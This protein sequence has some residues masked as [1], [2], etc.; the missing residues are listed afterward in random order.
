MP[1]PEPAVTPAAPA[2]YVCPMH[3]EVT[4]NEPARCPKCGMTLVK[5]EPAGGKP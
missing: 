3:P 5:K 4:S 2:E 1:A